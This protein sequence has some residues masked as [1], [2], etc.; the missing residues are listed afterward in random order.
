MFY[1][2]HKQSR[3]HPEPVYYALK[4]SVPLLVQEHIHHASK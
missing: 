4:Y 1:R 3:K 2:G